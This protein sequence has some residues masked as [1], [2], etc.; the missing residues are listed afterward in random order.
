MASS[1]IAQVTDPSSMI[2]NVGLP[3]QVLK[4]IRSTST[5]R[6]QIFAAS[7]KAANVTFTGRFRPRVWVKSPR[8]SS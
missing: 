4:D 3:K 2:A 1:E 5:T 6:L 8:R 7:W